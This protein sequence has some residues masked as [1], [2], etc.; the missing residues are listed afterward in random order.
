M[1]GISKPRQISLLCR[2][3][4]HQ[5]PVPF[6]SYARLLFPYL[7]SHH[8]HLFICLIVIP[9]HNNPPST[10]QPL[11]HGRLPHLLPNPRA[12]PPLRP[13]HSRKHRARPPAR[14][15]RSRKL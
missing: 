15:R 1:L 14:L 13:H 2:F 4:Y 9:Y 8:L 11:N 12:P 6:P 10:S 5:F 3:T 7:L